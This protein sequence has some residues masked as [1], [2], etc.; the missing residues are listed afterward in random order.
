MSTIKTLTARYAEAV[1]AKDAATLAALYATDVQVFDAWDV[2]SFDRDGWVE[3]LQN[4]LGS[5]G[6]ETVRVEFEDVRGSEQAD[7]GWLS[8][9]VI[10]TALDATGRP[11]RSLEDR[12]SWV[13]T[14]EDDRWVIT[15]AH[16]SAPIDFSTQKAMLK[17][18]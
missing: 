2:W 6:D 5:L 7:I 8:A 17:R 18:R 13:L 12:L 3:S 10:Y 14:K 9:T 16:T 4:W 11:L 15:H 1:L